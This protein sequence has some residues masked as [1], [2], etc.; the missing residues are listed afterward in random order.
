MIVQFPPLF[1]ANS[2]FDYRD[3]NSGTSLHYASLNE[4][5]DVALKIVAAC[6]KYEVLSLPFSRLFLLKF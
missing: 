1:V 5:P 6:P 4:N 2:P 3:E